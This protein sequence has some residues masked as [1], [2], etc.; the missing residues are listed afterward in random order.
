MPERDA[1]DEAF[2]Q[3]SKAFDPM[4]EQFEG[5]TPQEILQFAMMGLAGMA[6]TISDDQLLEVR[7]IFNAEATV[8][9]L[10]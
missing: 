5:Q 10:D 6:K 7:A 1:T 2:E 9:G 8:R 4:L 3:M